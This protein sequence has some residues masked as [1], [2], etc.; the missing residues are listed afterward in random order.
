MAAVT[1]SMTPPGLSRRTVAQYNRILKRMTALRTQSRRLAYVGVLL[2]LGPFW[3][4]HPFAGSRVVHPLR[5]MPRSDRHERHTVLGAD[6]EV[7]T[8]SFD[9]ELEFEAPFM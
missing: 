7:H 9:Y 1:A 8:S 6:L 5:K 4:G 2:R 3:P